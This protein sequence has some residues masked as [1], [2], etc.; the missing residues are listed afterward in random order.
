[1]LNFLFLLEFFLKSCKTFYFD[2]TILSF[3]LLRLNTTSFGT[4]RISNHA[5][6]AAWVFL[7]L[8]LLVV[9][10]LL[11]NLLIA[12]FGWVTQC[13]VFMSSYLEKSYSYM[14]HPNLWKI[15]IMKKYLRSPQF[16]KNTQN[17]R[18]YLLSIYL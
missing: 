16:Y 1:M 2:F 18:W 9:N 12:I 11:L 4:P 6:P 3:L 8:Y 17:L 10:V 14:N 15:S 5:E 7:A 13:N